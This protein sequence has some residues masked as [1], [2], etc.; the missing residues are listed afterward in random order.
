MVNETD[1]EY[2]KRLQELVIEKKENLDKIISEMCDLANKPYNDLTQNRH[3]R[4]Q[5]K[6]IAAEQALQYVQNKLHNFWSAK[7]GGDPYCSE[8][9]ALKGLGAWLNDNQINGVE[10][11]PASPNLSLDFQQK[12]FFL[13]LLSEGPDPETGRFQLNLLDGSASILFDLSIIDWLRGATLQASN[14]NTFVRYNLIATYELI[15]PENDVLAFEISPNLEL[16]FYIL[17]NEVK[18][19]LQSII[20]FGDD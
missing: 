13:R 20:P 2:L 14:G 11:I 18:H 1:D 7:D 19:L 15:D 12:A 17:P 8:R 16:A 4:L 10:I 9:L 6:Y 5:S 3:D